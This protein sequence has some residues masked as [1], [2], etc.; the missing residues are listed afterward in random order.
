MRKR[1]SI[2]SSL[3]TNGETR[4]TRCAEPIHRVQPDEARAIP[5]TPCDRSLRFA[6]RRGRR[7]RPPADDD[8]QS[9]RVVTASRDCIPDDPR[10]CLDRR[11]CALPAIRARDLCDKIPGHRRR[12]AGPVSLKEM[13][14]DDPEDCESFGD[15]EPE[16]TFHDSGTIFLTTPVYESNEN[17]TA[18]HTSAP[19]P[20]RPIARAS[21][22]RERHV[23]ASVSRVPACGHVA[24]AVSRVP[25]TTRS[26]DDLRGS[27]GAA[28]QSCHDLRGSQWRANDNAAHCAMSRLFAYLRTRFSCRKVRGAVVETERKAQRSES[29]P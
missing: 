12:R 10:G 29:S 3:A 18:N 9:D 21:L 7:Q 27:R 20:G 2:G 26:R 13:K 17:R 19:L 16:Q 15:I 14:I 6:P 4:Y 11:G 28:T 8:E 5:F 22:P 24:A 23:V 25:A 1:Q